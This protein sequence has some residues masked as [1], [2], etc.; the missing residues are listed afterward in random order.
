MKPFRLARALM[1]CTTCQQD[2]VPEGGLFLRDKRWICATCW[3]K[4]LQGNVDKGLNP[5][6]PAHVP[7]YLK[8]L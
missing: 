6:N 1:H 5:F 8:I 4:R 3:R 2:R 7:E